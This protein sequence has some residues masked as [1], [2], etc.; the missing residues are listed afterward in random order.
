MY[1][2]FDVFDT[3]LVRVWAYP[4]DLFWELGQQLAKEGIS[5]LSPE[6]WKNLRIE[7]ELV[8]RKSVLHTEVNLQ[9]IY[10]LLGSWLGWSSEKSQY[11]LEKEI[12]LESASLYSVPVT[13]KKI[14]A[15]RRENNQILYASDMYLPRDCILA[16][17]KKK[18]IW[19]PKDYLYVSCDRKV[20]KATGQMFKLILKE[21]QIKGSQLHHTGDNFHSDFLIARRL[22]IKSDLFTETHLNRYE[23]KLASCSCLPVNFRSLL[24]GASRLTR[25]NYLDTELRNRVI[26]STSANVIAPVLFGFVSWCLQQ[27]VQDGVERLYFISRDGQILHKLA[28]IISKTWRFNV[29]CRYLYGSRQAWHF[30]ALLEIGETELDWMFDST[31]FMSVR[32]VCNRV[33]ISPEQIEPFLEKK[34]FKSSMWDENLKPDDRISLREAFTDKEIKNFIINLAASY[35]ETALGYFLQEGM[36]ENVRFAIVDIGWH[37][38]LQASLSKILKSANLYPKDGLIGYYFALSKPIKALPPD[39]LRTY[40]LNPGIPSERDY[41]CSFRALI[42]LFVAADHGGTVRFAKDQDKYIPILRSSQD[43]R[44]IEWGIRTQHESICKFAHYLSLHLNPEDAIPE[45]FLRASQILLH[46]FIYQPSLQEAEVYGSFLFAEDQ[47]ETHFY[48]LA[49]SYRLMDTMRFILKGRH[50]HHNVWLP[51]TRARSRGLSKI[52]LSPKIIHFISKLRLL[53]YR[54]LTQKMKIVSSIQK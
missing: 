49:P 22:G 15:L 24:A 39:Q 26:W 32:S 7:A 53:K 13:V 17:L 36:G 3:C 33:N 11:V 14:K 35:R 47:S 41:L 19:D 43:F 44:A 46:D 1:Y 12:G 23:V 8:A 50:K 20:N 30:P 2:S 4:T 9:D 31:F 42:E 48:E 27:A 5:Q 37:G 16:F 51:A 38:R 10:A 6:E 40:F 25:L 34:S 45:H 21:H 54:L 28:Q 29:D 52:I 18:D